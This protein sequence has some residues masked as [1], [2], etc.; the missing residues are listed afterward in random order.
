[1]IKLDKV[2]QLCAFF[3]N[4]LIRLT[5]NQLSGRGNLFK[6]LK[7]FFW[8][9]ET[10]KKGKNYSKD[11]YFS[12]TKYL[13]TNT[14]KYRRPRYVRS[15]FLQFRVC[16]TENWPFFWNLSS[17]LQSSLVFLYANS[18]YASIF[19]RS[20]SL[21]YNE[22]NLYFKITSNIARHHVENSLLFIQE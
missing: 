2:T 9:H 13:E 5:V 16:A 22:G 14:L 1:M 11:F 4:R 15:F 18:L 8:I 6:Y 3:I 20:L 19:F 12:I 17:N 21:A 7:Y 10:W